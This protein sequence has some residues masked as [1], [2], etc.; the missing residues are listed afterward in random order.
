MN[1]AGHFDR[2]FCYR[3]SGMSLGQ[4]ECA[5]AASIRDFPAVF[6]DVWRHLRTWRVFLTHWHCET[7]TWS[8][9]CFFYMKHVCREKND[10]EGIGSG[11]GC[12]ESPTLEERKDQR[13]ICE[14]KNWACLGR[15]QM[16]WYAIVQQEILHLTNDERADFPKMQLCVQRLWKMIRSVLKFVVA[17][18]RSD[19][20]C[21]M[22][23][24]SPNLT[25]DKRLASPPFKAHPGWGTAG[26]L[27]ENY[28]YNRTTIGLRFH[29]ITSLSV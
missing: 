17:V 8:A 23:W 14:A 6:V 21:E 20:H 19:R 29:S 15:V 24:I 25:N 3:Y 7:R 1:P 28:G 26:E 9:G 10:F 12:H 5:T 11:G 27:V 16:I 18:N 13:V 2:D 4:C 22:H